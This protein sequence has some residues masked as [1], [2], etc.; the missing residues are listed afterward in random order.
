MREYGSPSSSIRPEGNAVWVFFGIIA[1][2][3]FTLLGWYVPYVL[4]RILY[5]GKTNTSSYSINPHSFNCSLPLSTLPRSLSLLSPS[6]SPSLPYLCRHNW[7]VLPPSHT[8]TLLIILN[9]LTILLST[10]ILHLGFFGRLL[11]LYKRNFLRVKYLTRLLNE[12]GE[13]DLDAWWNCR[14]AAV[15]VIV[16]MTTIN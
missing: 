6:P 10:L 12:I 13:A 11:S 5:R 16:I 9:F 15:T 7:Y 4:Q 3:T 1:A 8:A 2:L 14:S